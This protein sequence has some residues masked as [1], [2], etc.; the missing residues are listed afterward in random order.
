MRRDG[1]HG[2]HSGWTFD[3][4]RLGEQHLKR[5]FAFLERLIPHVLVIELRSKAQSG[6][7]V[8]ATVVSDE[9]EDRQTVVVANDSLPINHT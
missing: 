3:V 2:I 8:S 4:R 7:R 9:I 6:S 5:R 1:R